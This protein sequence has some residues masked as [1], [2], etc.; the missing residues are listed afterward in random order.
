LN[1]SLIVVS[2]VFLALGYVLI[3]RKQVQAHHRA[4]LTAT[5]FAALFL[6]V[7][8][9]RALLFDTKV[10]AGDGLVRASYLAILIS[11]T[12]LAIVVGPLVLVVLRR[13][14]RGDFLRHRALA[15]ITAPIWAYVV[16]TGWLIYWMLHNVSG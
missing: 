7:Y 3:R 9:T 8:L 10:F 5:T 12:I 16:V 13:A 15:R 14:F 4:M 2:G 11:H 6:V 1:T